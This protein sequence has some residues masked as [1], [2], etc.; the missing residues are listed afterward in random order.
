MAGIAWR[1]A[2][3]STGLGD[4]IEC[5]FAQALE[6]AGSAARTG[7]IVGLRHKVGESSRNII[8]EGLTVLLARQRTD[9]TCR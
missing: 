7:A 3:T 2:H 8:C 4:R 5:A 1:R 6:E 9:G